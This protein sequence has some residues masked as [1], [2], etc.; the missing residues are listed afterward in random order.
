MTYGSRGDRTGGIYRFVGRKRAVDESCP[1]EQ[2]NG[3]KCEATVQADSVGLADGTVYNISGLA[4]EKVEELVSSGKKVM[5]CG[6][7]ANLLQGKDCRH[8]RWCRQGARRV[9]L[10]S[11]LDRGLIAISDRKFRSSKNELQLERE[12]SSACL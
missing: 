2:A 1:A 12:R 9:P 11:S 4:E 7:D 3:Q 8:R 6:L 5:M 10:P